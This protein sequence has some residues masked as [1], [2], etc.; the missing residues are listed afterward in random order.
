MVF[1]NIL[2]FIDFT[3]PIVKKINWAYFISTPGL[4]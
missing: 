3:P 2:N 4:R 1:A